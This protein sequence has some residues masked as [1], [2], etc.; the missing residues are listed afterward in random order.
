MIVYQFITK[1]DVTNLLNLNNSI[2]KD[3]AIP[4]MLATKI[5]FEIKKPL[6]HQKMNILKKLS[7]S[8]L[9]GASISALCAIHCAVTPLLFA[10]KPIIESALGEHSHGEGVWATLDY[11]FLVLSVIAVWYSSQHTSHVKIKWI[12][13]IGWIFFAVGLLLLRVEHFYGQLLM[14]S[15]SIVLVITHLQN[16]YYCKHVKPE[17]PS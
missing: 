7:F 15:G 3:V 10:S 4:D 11:V 2:S 6:A 1:L 12:L 13:W 14:Y 16:Y 17:N 9:F 8:D 5:A